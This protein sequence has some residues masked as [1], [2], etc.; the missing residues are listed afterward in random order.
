MK[1]L[2]IT[3]NIKHLDANNTRTLLNN[4]TWNTVNIDMKARE[5]ISYSCTFN[6]Y[7]SLLTCITEHLTNQATFIKNNEEELLKLCIYFEEHNRTTT[8]IKNCIQEITE[9]SPLF[10]TVNTLAGIHT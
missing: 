3:L 8:K 5:Y 10:K 2:K 4:V 6:A 7:K 9:Y 1:P